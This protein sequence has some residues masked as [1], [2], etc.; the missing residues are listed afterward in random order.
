MDSSIVHLRR[1]AFGYGA[2]L[3][4]ERRMTHA[5]LPISSWMRYHVSWFQTQPHSCNGWFTQG[6]LHLNDDSAR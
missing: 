3:S 1:R 5:R 6:S 2:G 4:V